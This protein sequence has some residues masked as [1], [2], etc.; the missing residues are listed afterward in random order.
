MSRNVY[1]PDTEPEES[2]ETGEV[3][4]PNYGPWVSLYGFLHRAVRPRTEVFAGMGTVGL[5]VLVRQ[6]YAFIFGPGD[7]SGLPPWSVLCGV[8]LFGFGVNYYAVRDHTACSECGTAF[9]R[10]RVAK[11]PVRNESAVE[12]DSGVYIRETLECQ[13]CRN[14]TTEVYRQ[15][16][17]NPRRF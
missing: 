9:A 16:E 3:A 6:F 17:K 12:S 13:C 4:L 15:P 7:W 2:D 5:L 8:L 10:E 11:R 1:E 14:R